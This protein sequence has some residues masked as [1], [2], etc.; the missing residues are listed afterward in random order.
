MKQFLAGGAIAALCAGMAHAGGVERSPQSVSILFEE[1]TYAEFSFSAINPSVSGTQG[2]LGSGNMLKSYE[3]YSLGYKQALSDN[4]D[5]ALVLDQPIGADVDYS[6]GPGYR[7]EGTTAEL[8][9]NALTAFLRYK[10][11]ANVSLIGGIRVMRTSGDVSIDDDLVQAFY[12]GY[13]YSLST[14]TETDVGYV[15]GIAWE[16]PEIAARI[17]LTY[18]SSITQTFQATESHP[19]GVSVTGNFET[20][21]PESI[22]LEFQTGVAADTLLFGS[23]RWVNW[24][25]FKIEPDVYGV[26]YAGTALVD[27]E[28][29]RITYNL[30]L[31][32]K[33]NDTWSGAVLVSHED[34]TGSITGN[35]GPTDGYTSAGLAVTYTKGRMKLTGG[36]RY[37]DIGGATTTIGGDFDGNHG[38]GAGVRVGISF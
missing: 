28:D 27:Y 35:L 2:G 19:A 15:L 38:W 13:V 9:N 6:N 4:L 5:L 3:T 17:A 29:D 22:N 33:F 26:I 21:I 12:P 30:G 14:S 31:G 37:I 34:S 10:F 25:D 32:R 11:P 23:I 18:N 24:T 20:T 1:G 16:K 8:R 7:L 36:L